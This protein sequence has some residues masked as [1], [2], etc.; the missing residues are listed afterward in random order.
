[1]SV[2]GKP[3]PAQTGLTS[4][5]DYVPNEVV[6]VFSASAMPS[7]SQVSLSTPRFGI[8]VLDQILAQ[9]SAARMKRMLPG[10]GS[11]QSPGGRLLERAFLIR[12]S[13]DIDVRVLV[14]ELSA[15]PQFERVSLNRRYLKEYHGVNRAVPDTTTEFDQQWSLDHA[16]TRS[17]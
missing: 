14:G 9:R 2:P 10:V 11:C 1:M 3:P 13:Q 15:L 5:I 4:G 7:L 12:F 17:C 8:P 16:S 6:V